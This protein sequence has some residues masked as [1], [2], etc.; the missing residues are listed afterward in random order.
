MYNDWKNPHEH[1]DDIIDMPHHQSAKH[2]HMSMQAR[3]AQFAP[4]AALNGH[5]ETIHETARLTDKRIV[6]G[7]DEQTILNEK[8]QILRS[9]LKKDIIFSFTYFVPD[10]LKDGGAYLTN[11][12]RLAKIDDYNDLLIL[13]T[14]LKI[15]ISDILDI[16]SDYFAQFNIDS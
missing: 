10:R 6:L 5:F 11:Q 3:A 1:Y 12:G 9:A 8:L 14:G 13:D 7:I 15:C 2:P 4:F 16:E